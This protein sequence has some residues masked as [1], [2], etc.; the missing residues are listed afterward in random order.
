MIL[1]FATN[2]QLGLKCI[3]RLNFLVAHAGVMGAGLVGTSV[4]VS[5]DW[6]D[7]T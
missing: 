7:H 5:D 3:G 1:Q 2:D 6:N 4:I